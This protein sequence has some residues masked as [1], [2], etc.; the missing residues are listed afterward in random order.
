MVIRQTAIVCGSLIDEDESAGWHRIPCVRWNRVEGLLQ[1]FRKR[2]SSGL[3]QSG[4]V[5]TAGHV[6]A[7]ILHACAQPGRGVRPRP[8]LGRT[9]FAGAASAVA[10]GTKPPLFLFSRP[11][12]SPAT[13]PFTLK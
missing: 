10:P 4:N 12:H 13:F 3:I 1:L 5:G 6:L 8:R 7:P 2:G 9:A 11:G